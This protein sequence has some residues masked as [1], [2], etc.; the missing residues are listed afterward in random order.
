[1]SSAFKRAGID[2]TP[3]YWYMD[4]V[5]VF[6]LLVLNLIA[7]YLFYL[8]KIWYLPSRGLWAR[9]GAVSNMD[10]QQVAH[11]RRGTVSTLRRSLQAVN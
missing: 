11:S 10:A 2:P 7:C 1:M 9:S 5:C 6:C 4:Q 8:A 3:Y